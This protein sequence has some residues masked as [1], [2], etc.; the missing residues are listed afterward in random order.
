MVCAQGQEQ[1]FRLH[2][3]FWNNK[4]HKNAR[5]ISGNGSG[6]LAVTFYNTVVDGPWNIAVQLYF[7][8]WLLDGT[9]EQVS[10]CDWL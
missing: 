2:P 3:D 4:K 1:H 9:G 10:L 7:V 8:N 5:C 6:M